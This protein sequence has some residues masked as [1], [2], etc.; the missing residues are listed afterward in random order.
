MTK[1]LHLS[2]VERNQIE[3]SLKT[4]KSFR[5]IAI[6]L[7]RNSST[8]S[9]EVRNQLI[10]SDKSEPHRIQNR[11]IHRDSCDKCYLCLGKPDCTRLGRSCKQCNHKCANYAEEVCP[12]LSNTPTYVTDT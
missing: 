8:V 9:R 5:Q 10:F 6:E 12:K 1:Q 11:C 7:D 3:Q 2:I 4:R